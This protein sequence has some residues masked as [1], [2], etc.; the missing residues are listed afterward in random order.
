MLEKWRFERV[1]AVAVDGGHG[2]TGEAEAEDRARG[3]QV[4]ARVHL[5]ESTENRAYVLHSHIINFRTK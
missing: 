5:R 4:H 1:V 3:G 2:P